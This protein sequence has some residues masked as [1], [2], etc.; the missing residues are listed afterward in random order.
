MLRFDKNYYKIIMNDD[1]VS[2]KL[3]LIINQNLIRQLD[4]VE[5]QSIEKTRNSFLGVDINRAT[6]AQETSFVFL[7]TIY[8][9]DDD[10]RI[11]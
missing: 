4:N 2:V 5:N 8:Y 7:S 1:N 6:P 10:N 3:I 9:T 11:P